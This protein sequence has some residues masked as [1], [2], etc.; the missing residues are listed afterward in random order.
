MSIDWPDS[1]V[2][3]IARRR[4]VLFLGAGVSMNSLSE[5]GSS[6]PPDWLTF[7]NDGLAKVSSPTK[8]IR[9]LIS[10]GD[11][12][13]A[14]E[15]I[16]A[17]LDDD[18]NGFLDAAFVRPRYRHAEIHEHILNLDSRIVLTQNFDK[19]Y[20]T[21]AQTTTHNNI[22]VKSYTDPDVSDF[23]RGGMSVVMKA[24]GTIDVPAEM[25]FT[26]SEYSTARHEYRAFYS[27]LDAL[28]VTHT[29]LF[30]GCG[31]NDPDVRLLLEKVAF[32]YK[33][34]R[35]HFIC[36]PRVAGAPHDEVIK[37]YR[38]N[39]SLKSLIYDPK[40]GHAALTGS[41][42]SLAEQVELERREMAATLNW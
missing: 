40:N 11:Y 6:R 1:L 5:D 19:I 33:G 13:T 14:C 39:L 32:F 28:A 26:R 12:L 10:S 21:Y 37:S 36:M 38:D 18:W 27:M 20:D 22:R 4:C 29:F 35:P 8:H 15:L 9:A 24:H 3:D 25:V 2:R 16:K 31:V 42:K 17:R 41:I 23:V 34:S 30:I 7:L